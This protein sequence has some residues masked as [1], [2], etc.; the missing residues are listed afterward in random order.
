MTHTQTNTSPL[1][2]LLVI[3]GLFHSLTAQQ[4]LNSYSFHHDHILG[5]SFDLTI[6]CESKIV[7]NTAEQAALA[8]ITRLSKI[9]ST[10]D[11][12]SEL[13]L[14][15]TTHKQIVSADLLTVL[16]KSEFWRFKTNNAFSGRLGQLLNEWNTAESTNK[17]P[18]R[19]E[20]R[21]LAGEIKLAEV[22]IEPES[23]T[24]SSPAP[25]IWA[26][27]GIAKGYIIDKAFEAVQ[28]KAL[29]A[30]GIL[31]DIGGDIRLTGKTA[32]GNSWKVGVSNPQTHSDNT[33]PATTLQLE[34][35]AIAT[36]GTSQRNYIIEDKPY[37]HIVSAKSGWTSKRSMSSTVVATDAATADAL[38]TA[39]MTMAASESLKLVESIPRTEALIIAKDGRQFRSSGWH[40]LSINTPRETN[41]K[42]TNDSNSDLWPEHFQLSIDFNIPEMDIS[43]YAAPYFTLWITDEKRKL[44]RS[45]LMLGDSVRW[46]E[47]NYVWW[48]RYGRKEPILVDA[49]SEPSRNP[50]HYSIVWDGFDDFGQAV[51]QGNYTL[52]VEASREHG[53]HQLVKMKVVIGET[54]FKME[55]KAQGEIGD[56]RIYYGS[57][58]NS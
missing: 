42:K 7:A 15:N 55:N 22:I 35:G 21:I 16:S 49:I 27:D 8:E 43:E 28:S 12:E 56:I 4:E 54:T 58:E 24:V 19:P 13:S 23:S 53:K 45:L 9:L 33:A 32:Q 41:N 1:L 29:K 25:I 14:L 2:T 39:F 10:Y 34:H 3:L 5:T 47:E 46:Q 50:G 52:H 18:S 30:K 48:R 51:C 57:E 38:A 6:V 17:L 40:K 36:S 11:P 44:V 26:V 37:S 31:M 20:M